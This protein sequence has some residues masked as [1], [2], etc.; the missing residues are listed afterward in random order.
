MI[1]SVLRIELAESKY[2]EEASHLQHIRNYG[3]LKR[4][5]N[6]DCEMRLNSRF[7]S[8]LTRVMT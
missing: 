8:F 3:K 6:I 1:A 5:Q 7:S 2:A 4:D